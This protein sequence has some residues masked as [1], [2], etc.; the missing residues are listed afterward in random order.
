MFRVSDSQT[1]I[2]STDRVM[3]NSEGLYNQLALA[4]VLEP[5]GVVSKMGP[6][7]LFYGPLH[8]GI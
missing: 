5:V 7:R 4:K 1:D 8:V 3:L 2:P 6:L